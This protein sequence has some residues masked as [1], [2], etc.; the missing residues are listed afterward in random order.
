MDL[1]ALKNF[2]YPHLK[3][4]LR[5]SLLNCYM[6]S[7]LL[8]GVE[9]WTHLNK[10][11]AFEMWHTERELLHLVKIRKTSSRGHMLRNYKYHLPQ[12]IIKR[13]IEGKRGIG[14]RSYQAEDTRVG[15]SYF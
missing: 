2:C 9:T 14:K 8:Y 3:L 7:I 5:I 15:W 11:E 6:W 1:S 12:L 10:Q 4:N 13:K